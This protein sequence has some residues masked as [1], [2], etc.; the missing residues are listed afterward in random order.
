MTNN[1][2]IEYNKESNDELTSLEVPS[3]IC[4]LCR[5]LVVDM[6]NVRGELTSHCSDLANS[7]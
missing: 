5:L 3:L 1:P 2:L 4:F 7:A 6:K